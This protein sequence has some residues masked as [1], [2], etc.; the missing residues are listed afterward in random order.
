MHVMLLG[1]YRDLGLSLEKTVRASAVCC[2][3]IMHHDPLYM[4]CTHCMIYV[5]TPLFPVTIIS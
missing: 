3:Y 1:Q 2:S 4:I 5:C